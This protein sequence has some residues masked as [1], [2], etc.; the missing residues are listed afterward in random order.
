MIITKKDTDKITG[1]VIESLIRFWRLQGH[2]LSGQFIRSLDSKVREILGGKAIDFF[3]E[4]YGLILNKGVLAEKIPYNP[5]SGAAR[6]D[7]IEGLKRYALDRMRVS[8]RE[9]E[10]IAFA[11]AKTQKR[12]GMPTRGSRRFSKIGSRTGF[13][14]LAIEEV[15]AL[16][17]MVITESVGEFFTIEFK[18]AIV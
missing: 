18:S 8:R 4:D 16:I 12:E 15:E 10:R 5:G 2:H 17:R 13:I 7:Y 3:M 14:E 1:L 6:S 11:I 9:A